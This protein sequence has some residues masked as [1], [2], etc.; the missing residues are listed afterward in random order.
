[1]RRA[2][3]PHGLHVQA[4]GWE[5]MVWGIPPDRLGR[6]TKAI[7]SAV[8]TDASLVIFG[9]GASKR[10]GVFEAQCIVNL[11]WERFSRL[12]EFQAFDDYN[13]DS[14]RQI[15][16]EISVVETRSTNTD[17]EIQ[18]G[19]ERCLSLGIDRVILTSSPG[20]IGRCA[21]AASKIRHRDQRFKHLRISSEESDVNFFQYRNGYLVEAG[22]E[23]TAIFEPSHRGD[24][25]SRDI[26]AD[27]QP[28]RLFPQIFRVADKAR[29]LQ[30]I[31]EVF[32]RHGV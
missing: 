13:I 32:K 31:D 1:M 17:T 3:M 29:C 15:M 5:E 21:Q 19:F 24:D 22:V 20:H 4:H 27:L 12:K 25:P 10:D 2:I 28:N 6:A 11:M 18:F 8:E 9:T 26:P 14:L 30:K 16:E 7:Q 23:E